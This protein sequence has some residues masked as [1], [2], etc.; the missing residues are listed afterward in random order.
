MIQIN[1]VSKSFGKK[2]VLKNISLEIKDGE[3]FGLLGSNGSGKTTLME[4]LVGQLKP[5]SGEILV[6]NNRNGYK[7]IGIQFQEGF[8]PKGVTSSLI[9]N[10][11]KKNSKA[12]KSKEVQELINIFE[13]EDFLKK[14]LNSL[15]GGQKQRLNTLLSVINDPKYICLDEMITGL[16]LKMQFKLIDY[17]EKMKEKGKTIVIISHIPEEIEKL[18]DRFVIL[19]DWE[20]FYSA[21][22]KKAVKEFG[23]IRNLMI[24]YYNDELKKC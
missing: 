16:D 15:S 2:E 20:L 14:D 3:V 8:W 9:I 4:I 11:F 12:V 7:N 23:S 19:K 10:Y 22:V 17:F 1:N 24:S 5:S 21:E 6:D 18:C 13:I